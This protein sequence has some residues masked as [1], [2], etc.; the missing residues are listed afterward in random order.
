MKCSFDKREEYKKQKDCNIRC[1][2]YHTCTRSEYIEK[3]RQK[4]WQN[5]ECLQKK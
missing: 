4:R 5:A 3:E 2:Y 1:Q